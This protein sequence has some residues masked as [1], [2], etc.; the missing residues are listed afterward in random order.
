MEY[1]AKSRKRNLTED[2]KLV[3]C[4]KIKSLIE[5][6]QDEL[7]DWEEKELRKAEESLQEYPEVE[8]QKTVREHLQETVDCAQS[9]FETYGSYFSENEKI[10]V[11]T[12]CKYHDIGKINFVFQKMVNPEEKDNSVSKKIKQ[13]PHGFLSAVSISEDEFM[14]EYPQISKEEFYA[15]ITAIYYH[16][17]R[18]DEYK[19]VEIKNYCDKYYNEAMKDYLHV[20]IWETFYENEMELF[21]KNSIENL[22][23]SIPEGKW[24]KYLLVK[25][26]LNKFD[27]AVS[28]GYE[29]AEEKSDLVDKKLKNAIEQKLGDNLRPAQIYMWEHKDENLVITA[30]TGSGKTEAALLWMDGE[31]S[32]YTLP[33]KVSSNAIYDRI[34]KQYEYQDVSLL[35][36]DSMVK[37]FMEKSEDKAKDGETAEEDGYSRYEKAKLLS[38]PITICTVDQLFKF[39]YKALGTEIF[40]AT[41]KYSKLVLDEIQAYSP[42]VVASILY[43]LKT[44]T[45]MGGRF[46]IITATFPPVL[47]MFMAKYGLV[48]GKDYQF[49]DFAR[50]ADSRRHIV[51]V[52]DGELDIEEIAD[53]GTERKVL[54]ICNTV[55]KAQM[56]Y[57]EISD[58]TEDVFLLHSRFIRKD[59][60]ILED[61]IM[62][63]SRNSKAT[64]I[65]VTTQI[66]EASLDI[67]FDILYTEMAPADSLLQRMGRCNR[68]QRYE[69]TEANIIVFDNESGVSA[70]NTGVYNMDLYKRSVDKLK[71]YEYQV[72]TERDKADYI[73]AVYNQDEIKDTSY[74]QEIEKY[75]AHFAEV[76][77]LEYTIDELKKKGIR[78]INSITVVP[79]SVKRAH[80]S[81]FDEC[82]A[83][84]R[85]PHIGVRIK[86]ILRAKMNDYTLSLNLYNHRYPEGVDH[87]KISGTEIHMANLVYEFD[88]S[89]RKG[90]GLLME[91]KSEE[92]FLEC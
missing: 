87:A 45:A 1:Y 26:L 22:N 74:Y 90:R 60:A 80:Y 92:D 3:L 81:L 50:E 84:I 4:Q 71:Q 59:R 13:I 14:E 12:A 20:E 29:T 46:A 79:D 58:L 34:K 53:M 62:N 42:R 37:Y 35:H 36:S 61:A 51:E 52:R 73:D 57:G 28:A 5:C 39:V 17:A 78:D 7:Y 8:K 86:S 54:V 19:G 21:L 82:S 48:E 33:L 43:G 89:N 88:A 85:E 77:P 11:T 75:M 76:N 68:A 31:K 2:E 30:P 15:M 24:N 41:L 32:F 18:N 23:M 25:G 70:K 56:I 66:V 16:H 9:F 83:L 72:F 67:D 91:K 47:G 65:W 55:K 10:L 63:F 49:K 38:G 69:P 44:I 27:W 6:L 40:P 64:G